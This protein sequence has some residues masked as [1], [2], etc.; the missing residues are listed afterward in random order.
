MVETA[1]GS[2]RRR[3]PVQLF[4]P[5]LA[6][7][8]CGVVLFAPPV[9]GDGDTFW[10]IAA[11]EWM[12]S[13]RAVLH[14]DP[15]SF[16]VYGR[17]WAPQEWL[18]ELAMGAAF[19]AGGWSG[20]LVLF[21]LAV[22]AGFWLLARALYRWLAPLP[23][24]SFLLLAATCVAPSLLA[25]PHMLAF[26]AIVAWSDG[27]LVA[28]SQARVPPWPLLAVMLL[29]ANLHASFPVGLVL[30]AAFGVE[31]VMEAAS[32]RGR[33]ARAWASFTAAAVAVCVLTPA[34]P[35][36]L[37]FPLR[38]LRMSA[39]AHIPEWQST[40]FADLPPAELIVLAALYAALSRGIRLPAVRLALLL[41][42][43]H[44]GFAHQRDQLLLGV[45]GA[46]LCAEPVG[47]QLGM[48][49]P[50]PA[51]TAQ[52]APW[53]WTA[54]AGLLI[55]LRLAVPVVRGDAPS[56]PVSALA[57]VPTGLRAKPVLN[58]YAFGGYLIFSGVRPYVDSRADLYGDRFLAAYAG[59]ELDDRDALAA[60]LD[61]NGIDWTILPP[62]SRLVRLL[63]AMPGWT[64]LYA[65]R[66][67]VV[68]ARVTLA[69][70]ARS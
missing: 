13:H 57:H 52:R 33:V 11:G 63:D 6:L 24:L 64:R 27:L 46:I 56:A 22:G 54:L 34:G 37:L 60:M 67:A 68:H 69:A 9:L 39:L 42:L 8:A 40:D 17:A 61:R 21:G 18:A 1:L 32:D 25:R 58:D 23:A 50:A 65:D 36:G 59:L 31:A 45:L 4:G 30:A 14:A 66:I 2:A 70:M 55:A 26:P 48:H 15:F 16:T 62:E 3:G 41:V 7:L 28:R 12:L 29:W 38:L 44:L 19:R 53:G 51:M 35:D 5:G 49:G 10:Q 47:R 43:V 20:L